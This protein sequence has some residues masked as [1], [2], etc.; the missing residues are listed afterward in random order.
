MNV[1]DFKLD[2]EVMGSDKSVGERG[3]WKGQVSCQVVC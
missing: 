3:K 2:D 1:K